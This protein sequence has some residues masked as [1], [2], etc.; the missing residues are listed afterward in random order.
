MSPPPPGAPGPERRLEESDYRLLRAFRGELRTFLRW[1]EEAA[2]E[3]GLTPALHQL[4][5]VLCGHPDRP[6][7][8]VGEVAR[9]LRVRHHSAVELAH[10]AEESGLIERHRDPDDHRQVR[11]RL[12][13]RGRERLEELTRRH[14]PRI[15]QLARSLQA[16]V[17][18]V[19]VRA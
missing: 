5:L 12:T 8:T 6:G 9:E 10:R 1:S 2:H 17:E 19:P 3:A 13:A 14:L 16:V 18:R 4:L 15:E 7:P 11:L